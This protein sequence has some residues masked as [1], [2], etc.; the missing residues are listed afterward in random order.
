MGYLLV[1]IIYGT[2]IW[3]ACDA[4]KIKMYRYKQFFDRSIGVFV[5]CLMLWI[6][7]FPAYLVIRWKITSGKAELKDEYKGTRMNRALPLTEPFF[8]FHF[9]T[10]VITLV[11]SVV[12]VILLAKSIGPVSEYLENRR[13]RIAGEMLAKLAE[14]VR[15]PDASRS[16]REASLSKASAF[17]REARNIHFR[18]PEIVAAANELLQLVQNDPI[19]LENQARERVRR[20]TEW[21]TGE[22]TESTDGG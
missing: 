6:I 12:G 19:T 9:K 7:C 1:L 11:V 5:G 21:R 2:S 13:E 16:N 3:A 18:S 22:R 8:V 17:A 20:E 15:C 10:I 4:A 14:A